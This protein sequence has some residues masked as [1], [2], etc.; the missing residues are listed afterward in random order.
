MQGELEPWRDRIDQWTFLETSDI[1]YP[2]GLPKFADMIF[3]DTSHHLE[4]TRQEIATYSEHVS[5]DGVM[6][7]HDTA[8]F[9]GFGVKQAIDEFLAREVQWKG[10]FWED[11]NGLGLLYH[12]NDSSRVEDVIGKINK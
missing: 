10:Y 6:L 9:R 7:F 1:P 5:E 11:S 4:E 12:R 3:I 8:A 2:G